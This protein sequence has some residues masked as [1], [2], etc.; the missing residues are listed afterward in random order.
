MIQMKHVCFIQ[1]LLFRSLQYLPRCSLL[2]HRCLQDHAQ[3]ITRETLPYFYLLLYTSNTR[4]QSLHNWLFWST[5]WVHR[6][7]TCTTI[8][9]A[10]LWKVSN[11]RN[12]K[13]KVNSWNVPLQNS[14]PTSVCNLR[15]F[16]PLAW[17]STRRKALVTSFPVFFLIDCT[18]AYLNNKS[19]TV[20]R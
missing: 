4:E 6:F 8:Y 7:C 20:R 9:W 19:M 11:V 1:K 14:L 15:R 12:A 16:L 2:C 17:V 13:N 3:K 5:V 10:T 18:H